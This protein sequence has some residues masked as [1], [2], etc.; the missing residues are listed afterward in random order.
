MQT[1]ETQQNTTVNEDIVALIT[2]IQKATVQAVPSRL[3]KLKGPS[4]KVSPK[5]R[6]LLLNPREKYQIWKDNEKPEG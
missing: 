3:V 2:A 6:N 5:V 4:W 1:T